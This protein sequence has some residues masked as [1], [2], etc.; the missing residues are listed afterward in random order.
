VHTSLLRQFLNEKRV[1]VDPAQIEKEI[2]EYRRSSQENG[3]SLEK[4]LADMN[5]TIEQVREQIS[6]KLAW[7]K[8]IDEA[9][10]DKAL[11]EYMKANP[12]VFNGTTVKASHI[13]INADENA[14]E[15][16]KAKAK[17]KLAEIKKEILAG[18]ITF[19]DAANKYSEDPTN[20]EQPSGGDL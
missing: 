1:K 8:F 13:Q 5:V 15:A 7:H 11:D 2:D 17:A 19:A 14:S 10:S 20:K 6:D 3:T 4:A 9:A 18:K 16:D 12:D